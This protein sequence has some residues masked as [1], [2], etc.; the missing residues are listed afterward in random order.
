MCTSLLVAAL[1]TI[2]NTQTQP[3][4]ISGWMDKENAVYIHSGLLSNNNKE[5]NLAI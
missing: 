5:G 1:F 2:V 3:V 4:S